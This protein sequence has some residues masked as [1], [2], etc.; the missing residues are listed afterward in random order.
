MGAQ[1][2]SDLKLSHYF[3]ITLKTYQTL[4]K[5]PAEK[6]IRLDQS[7]K[8]ELMGFELISSRKSAPP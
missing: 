6:N 7:L 4:W 3:L 1:R 8:V 2:K 5:N